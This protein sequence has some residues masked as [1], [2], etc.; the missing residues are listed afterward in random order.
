MIGALRHGLIEPP[1]SRAPLDLDL[2]RSVLRSSS[3][4]SR[5]M[6]SLE[7]VPALRS[8]TISRALRLEDLA[9]ERLVGERAV[10]VAV[11]L[12]LARPARPAG[13]C[14]TSYRPRMRSIVSSR[15][16]SSAAELLDPGERRLGGDQ[17]RLELLALLAR[18][19]RR[20]RSARISERQRQPLEHERR[21]DHREGEEDDQVALREVRRRARARRPARPRR[22]CPPSRRSMPLLPVDRGA[23]AGSRGGRAR[24]SRTRSSCCQT[25]RVSDHRGA[26]RGARSRAASPASRP[27]SAVEDRRQLQPDQH[28]QERVEQELQQLPHAEALQAR[29]AARRSP[30]PASRRSSRP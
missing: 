15:V 1:T 25:S 29:G 5:C 24:G 2:R 17:P 18:R 9:H 3:R 13:A 16:H 7:I 19:R 28:E 30:A 8:R 6:T 22:A 27:S 11:V 10:L 12:D 14:G 20:R 21:E 23:R 4:S 26:D